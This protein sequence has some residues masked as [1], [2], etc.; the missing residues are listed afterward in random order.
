[1]AALIEN[2]QKKITV[3]LKRVQRALHDILENL[4]CRDKEISLLFIDDDGIR[5]INKE[6]LGRDYP[7]NVI[8]FSM[9]EGEFGDINPDMLGDIIISVETALRNAKDAEIEF[10]E[11]LDF[12]MIHGIL[13]LLGYDHETSEADARRMEEKERELFFALNNYMIE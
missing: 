9:T 11:E 2:R 5:E 7:T 10:E 13:H 1:M 8:A 3:D 12:L 4:D 6:Y